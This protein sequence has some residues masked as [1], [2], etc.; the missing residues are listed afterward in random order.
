MK[1][2]LV[3]VQLATTFAVTFPPASTLIPETVTPVP[4]SGVAVTFKVFSVW[5]LSL[6]VAI[7]EFEAALPCWRLMV[8]PLMV[9]TALTFRVKVFVLVLPQL[10]VAVTVTV[11]LP[12]G[13][14][15]APVGADDDQPPPSARVLDLDP[16]R[17]G[18]LHRHLSRLPADHA[19][20]DVLDRAHDP[21]S[22][23]RAG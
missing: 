11:K 21:S 12:A 19:A 6:T 5:S 20:D 13:P 2:E 14:A 9:G 4:V 16:A 10:S 22:T 3:A 7:C 18:V 23:V 8:V 15:L 1:V 17:G